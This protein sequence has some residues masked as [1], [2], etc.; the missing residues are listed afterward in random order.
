ME[1]PNF[2]NTFMKYENFKRTKLNSWNKMK[3]CK[4]I[5]TVLCKYNENPSEKMKMKYWR[6]KFKKSSYPLVSN[7]IRIKRMDIEI[8]TW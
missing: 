1:N 4:L 3:K 7:N 8:Q 2:V 6:K 5:E